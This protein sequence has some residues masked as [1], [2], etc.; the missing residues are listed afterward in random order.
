MVTV[1][2]SKHC[3]CVLQ[4]CSCYWLLHCVFH[5]GHSLPSCQGLV[6][7]A[8]VNILNYMLILRSIFPPPPPPLCHHHHYHLRSTIN[9][10]VRCC[11][12]LDY[13]GSYCWGFFR[14]TALNLILYHL[15]SQVLEHNLNISYICGGFHLDCWVI[16]DWL[17]RDGNDQENLVSAGQ[18]WVLD[19]VTGLWLGWKVWDKLFGVWIF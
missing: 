12:F 4:D 9:L 16:H 17:Q 11:M 2:Q 19:S 15:L 3:S 8:A 7:T 5:C 13:R 10:L 14:H 1:S 18:P 6:W